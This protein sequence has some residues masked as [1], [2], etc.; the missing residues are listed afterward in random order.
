LKIAPKTIGTKNLEAS[1]ARRLAALRAGR[2]FSLDQLS[3]KCGISRATLS[4]LERGRSSPTA[5]MLG[6]LCTVYGQTTSQLM[7]DAESEAP[8]LVRDADQARW[9][10]IETGFARRIVS[11]PGYGLRGEIVEATLPAGAA[12][13]YNSPPLPGLEHHLFML[14]GRLELKLENSLFIL[15]RGDCL[16]YRLAGASRFHCPGRKAARYL[17]A[18]WH[19]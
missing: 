10:D 17:V 15:N 4:R 12:I 5:A 11:P 2:G 8:Q 19:P 1:L 6:S 9:T 14:D 18:I 16:R 3:Q 13:A 7:T